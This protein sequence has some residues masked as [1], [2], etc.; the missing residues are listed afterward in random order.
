M[1]GRVMAMDYDP[2]NPLHKLCKFDEQRR[3]HLLCDPP[4]IGP[5]DVLFVRTER[6][7]ECVGTVKLV[8]S[9]VDR[10]DVT[11]PGVFVG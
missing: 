1:E 9:V 3:L 6:G 8:S 5:D 2:S 10:V 11:L 4:S 7:H